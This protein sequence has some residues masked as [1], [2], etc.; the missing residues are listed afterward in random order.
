LIDFNSQLIIK[1]LNDNQGIVSVIIF[2]ITII[3]GW[4]SGIFSA[5]M[6]KPK[7]KMS[8]IVGPTFCCTYKTGNTFNGFDAHR[9][10]IALYLNIANIG[11]AASSIEKIS[12]GYH[13][14]LKP[15]SIQWLKFAI[16]WFWLDEQTIALDDFQIKIGERIKVYP[17]LIQQNSLSPNRSSTFLDVGRSTNGVVYFEQRE[18]WGGCLPFC[19]QGKVSI[20]LKVTDT[21]GKAHTK[22]FKIPFFDLEEARKYNPTFGTTHFELNQK[23]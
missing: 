7:F 15:F 8:L 13:W 2:A 23:K 9:T 10:C 20:K 18:S 12:I 17:F 1:I 11:S 16:G 19:N 22:S 5:L 14:H 21:F 6:R 3:F 4:V